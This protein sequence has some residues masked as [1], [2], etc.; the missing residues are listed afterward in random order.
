MKEQTSVLSRSG[1]VPMKLLGIASITLDVAMKFTSLVPHL[2]ETWE[3]P[4]VLGTS[5]TMCRVAWSI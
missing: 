3:C 1:E 4:G 5:S 2:P